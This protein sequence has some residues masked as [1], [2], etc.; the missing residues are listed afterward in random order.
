MFSAKLEPRIKSQEEIN[1]LFSTGKTTTEF[2]V[3]AIF[4]IKKNMEYN[5]TKLVFAVPKKKI[6]SAVKR[7][8][9]KRRLKEA[10]RLNKSII[11]SNSLDK[12]ITVKIAF[13]YL[14]NKIEP[15]QLLE[16]KIVIILQR[17]SKYFNHSDLEIK[18]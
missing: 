13:I 1:L 6:R 7:N 4:I 11:S 14:T 5:S 16:E 17:L 15:M 8:L 2:P 9:V 18:P 3:K 10:Y 12:N